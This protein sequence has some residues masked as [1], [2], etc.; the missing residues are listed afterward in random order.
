MERAVYLCQSAGSKSSQP[1]KILFF[2]VMASGGLIE[3]I[4]RVTK[5]LEHPIKQQSQP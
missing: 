2:K 5:F 1:D 3:N 4:L